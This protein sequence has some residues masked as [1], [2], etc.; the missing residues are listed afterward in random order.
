MSDALAERRRLRAE[1][2][3]RGAARCLVRF[4]WAPPGGVSLDARAGR[5]LGLSVFEGFRLGGDV[6]VDPGEDRMMQLMLSLLTA[7]RRPVFLARGRVVGR[8]PAG[9]LCLGPGFELERVPD[10]RV[11]LVY[12]PDLADIAEARRRTLLA[13]RWPTPGG[14][15]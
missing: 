9:E 10:S 4:G 12:R 2:K 14:A 3:D 1:L 8:D 11:W 15:A 5:S 13:P 6:Y 7:E